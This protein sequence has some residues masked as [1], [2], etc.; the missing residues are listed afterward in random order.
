MTEFYTP[1][2]SVLERQGLAERVVRMQEHMDKKRP[3]VM[4]V[5]SRLTASGFDVV[6]VHQ[7]RFYLRYLNVEAMFNHHFIKYWFLDSWKD[8]VPQEH[9][10][11]VFSELEGVLNRQAHDEGEIRLSIPY[12]TVDCIKR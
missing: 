10:Q 9:W 5:E 12:A 8:L 11:A 7:E 4:Q 3:S 6:N 1:F 2:Q